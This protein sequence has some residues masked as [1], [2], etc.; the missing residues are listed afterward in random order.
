M[1]SACLKVQRTFC[2]IV[3]HRTFY[4]I[5]S[6]RTFCNIMNDRNIQSE[7]F[8]SQATMFQKVVC[9]G[10]VK[11]KP[12]SARAEPVRV[13]VLG[14]TCCSCSY[15]ILTTL[16][17]N[18]WDGLTSKSL[19]KEDVTLADPDVSNA[20]GQGRYRTAEASDCLAFLQVFFEENSQYY[21]NS[22]LKYLTTMWPLPEVYIFYKKNTI[23]PWVSIKYLRRLWLKHYPEYHY[24][25]VK[26]QDFSRCAKCDL[27][28]RSYKSATTDEQL[29]ACTVLHIVESHIFC[30]QKLL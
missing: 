29:R 21:P 30:F 19:E 17:K 6:H 8:V 11:R 1:C 18:C 26:K 12:G 20:A 27:I 13:S 24:A 4:N 7:C 2:N 14:T 15:R 3:S 5:V 9:S 22:H 25:K 23:P 28:D 10:C 16:S